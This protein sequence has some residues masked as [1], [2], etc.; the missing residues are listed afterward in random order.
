MNKEFGVWNL[1]LFF[2]VFTLILFPTLFPQTAYAQKQNVNKFL[3]AC[4]PTGKLGLA[5]TDPAHRCNVY[6]L[7]Q[8]V[9]NLTRWLWYMS[10]PLAGALFLY[11]GYLILTA[12]GDEGR[13]GQGKKI[14]TAAVVGFIIVMTSWLLV[15]TI[16]YILAPG[17]TGGLSQ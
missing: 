2:S 12:A 11:A 8:L 7:L 13:I 3:P 6:D 16:F 14:I 9:V 17:Y 4:E 15:R 1:V 10:I 5:V